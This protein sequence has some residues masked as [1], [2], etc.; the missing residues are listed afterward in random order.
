MNYL[1]CMVLRY[2]ALLTLMLDMAT[3][4]HTTRFLSLLS[5]SINVCCLLKYALTRIVETE[6][7]HINID[8]R[9]RS[10]S[11]SRIYIDHRRRGIYYTMESSELSEPTVPTFNHLVQLQPSLDVS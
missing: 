3:T 1:S 5:N 8:V 7:F 6:G 10:Q 11:N 9:V 2:A 4:P